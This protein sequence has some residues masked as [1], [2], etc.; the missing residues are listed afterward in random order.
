[1]LLSM[2]RESMSKAKV[3]SVCNQKGGVGKS[4]TVV[5]LAAALAKLQRHVLV[6]DM[7]PQ[8]NCSDT[9]GKVSPYEAK[10]TMYDVLMNRAKI[11]ST[12]MQDSRDKYKFLIGGTPVTEE[13]CREIGAD[14]YGADAMASIDATKQLMGIGG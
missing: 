7:D 9:L 6:L 11:V 2:E 3:I 14:G 10:F 13:F 4:T 12:A 8:A 5:N 1:M